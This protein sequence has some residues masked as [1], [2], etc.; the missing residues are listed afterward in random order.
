MNVAVVGAGGRMGS[1]FVQYF[2]SR[3]LSVSVYDVD[4]NSLKFAFPSVTVAPDLGSCVGSVDFVLICVP[5]RQT[6]AVVGQCSRHMKSGAALGEISSVKHKSHRAL[7]RIRKDISALC[8]HPMFGPGATD[9]S[10][11]KILIVPV[12][13]KNRELGLATQL[14]DGV[15]IIAVPSARVHDD[16]IGLILGLTYFA[17]LAFASIIPVKD[18]GLLEEISGTTFR[19]QTVLAESILT[20]DPELIA[21]LIRDNPHALSRIGQYLKKARTLERLA[22]RD[23]EGLLSEIRKLEAH[24]RSR[25]DLQLSYRRLYDALRAIEG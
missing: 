3:N 7:S 19:L 6:P 16:S 17:N 24:L 5:V 11:L 12:R 10:Q 21:S 18:M 22:S 15:R 14:F 25:R 20:D 13:N 8:I 4:R 9:S 2:A 23:H 1:W